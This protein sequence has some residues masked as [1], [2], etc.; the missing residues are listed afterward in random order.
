MV[1]KIAFWFNAVGTQLTFWPLVII[2]ADGMPRRYWDY[3]VDTMGPR[4]IDWEWWHHLA[5]YG[6]LINGVGLLLMIA[7]WLYAVFGGERVGRNPWGSKSL[8]WTHAS[9]PI[10]PGNFDEDVKVTAEWTPYNYAK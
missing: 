5:T 1:A 10:G 9:Y 7:G 8:E 2:G 4:A 3:S 6:A